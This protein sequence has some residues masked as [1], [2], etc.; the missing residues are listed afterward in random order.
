MRLTL[1]GI[2]FICISNSLISQNR[3]DSLGILLQNGQIEELS[4]YFNKQIDIHI[5]S[6]EGMFS[7]PQ[8]RKILL[9]FFNKH[10]IKSFEVKHSGESKANS[11]YLIGA[12]KLDDTTYRSYI[13]YKIINEKMLIS[14]FRL[15]SEE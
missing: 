3:N 4:K 12:L 2:L 5:P 7:P 8:A 15:E 6:R 9:D 14:E 13:L 1:L 10:S 11:V